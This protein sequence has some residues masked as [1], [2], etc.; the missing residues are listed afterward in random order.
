[1]S[2]SDETAVV[3]EVVF[4]S[5]AGSTFCVTL[6]AVVVVGSTFVVADGRIVV[7]VTA[8]VVFLTVVEVSVPADFSLIFSL[9]LELVVVV[10]VATTGGFRTNFSITMGELVMGRLIAGVGFLL[11]FRVVV[12]L[13]VLAVVV[14]V[15]IVVVVAA[16]VGFSLNFCVVVV[17][18]NV[19][20]I[21]RVG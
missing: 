3:D 16:A 12:A 19:E 6:C 10:A 7:V 13:G 20:L 8:I 5:S 2:S 11:G 1:M 17:F 15:C 4:V 21:G 9:S 18:D 14:V